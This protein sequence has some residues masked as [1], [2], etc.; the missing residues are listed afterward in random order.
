MKSVKY[1]GFYHCMHNH[2]IGI[3]SLTSK[4]ENYRL[5]LKISMDEEMARRSGK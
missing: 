4:E 2:L 1:E 5:S 3:F